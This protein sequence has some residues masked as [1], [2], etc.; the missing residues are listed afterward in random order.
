MQLLQV[1]EISVFFSEN[2]YHYKEMEYCSRLTSC[3][4]FNTICC[5]RNNNNVTNNNNVLYCQ[6]IVNFLNKAYKQYKI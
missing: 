2:N 1:R 5:G 4:K 3:E 6:K